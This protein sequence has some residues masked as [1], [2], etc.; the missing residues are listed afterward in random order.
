MESGEVLVNGAPLSKKLKRKI[1]YIMQQDIFIA[2]QTVKETLMDTARLRLP[3]KL[4]IEEKEQVVTDTIANMNLEKATNTIVGSLFPFRRGISGGEKKRL[5]IANELLTN[6]S[7]LLIDEPTSGLDSS[8]SFVVLSLLK[9]LAK[10]VITM[11]IMSD[12]ITYK[13]Y[14]RMC[15]LNVADDCVSYRVEQSLLPFI[16]RPARSLN[17]LIN[18]CC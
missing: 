8:T 5:N 9:E 18:S 11:S 14:T 3:A 12:L 6:P 13:N 15:F 4:T 1:A 16:N 10:E 2:V 7:L 17:C